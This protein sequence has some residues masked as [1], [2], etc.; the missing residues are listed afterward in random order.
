MEF[1]EDVRVMA[2]RLDV[3]P[4]RLALGWG[5]WQLVGTTSPETLNELREVAR[6]QRVACSV[7]GRVVDGEQVLLHH[8]GRRGPLLPLDS[9]RFTSESWFTAGLDGYISTM[10]AAD[11][12][13][14]G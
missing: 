13:A 6:R 8:Q 1:A 2:R 12:V 5:D 9:E 4:V 11:L 14:G 10:L 7:L 3:D